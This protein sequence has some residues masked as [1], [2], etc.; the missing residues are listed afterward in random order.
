[1]DPA[2]AA[3]RKGSGAGEQTPAQG[4]AQAS[5][6]HVLVL[7]HQVSQQIHG[8]GARLAA[9]EERLQQQQQQQQPQLQHS[10]QQYPQQHM[11][12]PSQYLAQHVSNPQ[13]KFCTLPVGAG[14]RRCSTSGGRLSAQPTERKLR[15]HIAQHGCQGRGQEGAQPLDRGRQSDLL[16]FPGRARRVVCSLGGNALEVNPKGSVT[17]Q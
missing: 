8:Q 7:L 2:I 12:Q 14:S 9:I 15:E 11:Q 5:S 6:Q 10:Q 4:T 13:M 16:Y 17:H 3:A 1:M